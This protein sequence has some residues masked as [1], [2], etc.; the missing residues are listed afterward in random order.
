M[1]RLLMQRGKSNTIMTTKPRVRTKE[2][3]AA[4]KEVLKSFRVERENLLKRYKAE[5]EAESIL[6]IKKKLNQVG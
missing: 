6:E 2:D 4:L 3:I 1:L 5:L